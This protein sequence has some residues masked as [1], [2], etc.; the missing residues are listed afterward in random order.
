MVKGPR[1]VS[2]LWLVYT[3]G[4]RCYS[5]MLVAKECTEMEWNRSNRELGELERKEA[6]VSRASV[7]HRTH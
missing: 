7:G 4:R 2:R 3:N 1:G 5:Q 6:K